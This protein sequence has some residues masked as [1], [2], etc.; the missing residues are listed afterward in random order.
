MPPKD[1]SLT[2][3]DK[4]VS[5]KLIIKRQKKVRKRKL[6]LTA[7]QKIAIDQLKNENV[8][9][10]DISKMLN[11]PNHYVIHYLYRHKNK[12][13]KI[14]T[15]SQALEPNNP[16]PPLELQMAAKEIKRL[17]KKAKQVVKTLDRVAIDPSVLY[18]YDLK[19]IAPVDILHKLIDEFEGQ[20]VQRTE[21][22]QICESLARRVKVGDFV[23]TNERF[24][25]EL[26]LK[27][28]EASSNAMRNRV[29]NVKD[30]LQSAAGTVQSGLIEKPKTEVEAEAPNTLEDDIEQIKQT[31]PL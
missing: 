7:E 24:H 27:W 26:L 29:S 16:E 21:L 6:V 14:K 20:D 23:G 31:L 28:Y 15:E 5:N 19:S 11:I 10:R 18:V 17:S 22:N 12:V 9:V 30:I 3:I 1:P 13:P 25:Y 8:P 2:E 4:S